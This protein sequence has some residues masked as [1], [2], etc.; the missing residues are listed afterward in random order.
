MEYKA[1]FKKEDCLTFATTEDF[2]KAIKEGEINLSQCV[3]LIKGSRAMGMERIVP[4]LVEGG[5]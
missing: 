3:V 1:G 5:N 4:F 2:L